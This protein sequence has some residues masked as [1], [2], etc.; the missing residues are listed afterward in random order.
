MKRTQQEILNRIEYVKSRDVLGFEGSDLIEFLDFENAKEYLK[1]EYVKKVEAGSEKWEQPNPV[2]LIKEYLPF[3]WDKANNCRGLSAER[4]LCRFA[5]W[6]W[7]D[8][9]E[10]E[11]IKPLVED[12]SYYGKPELVKISEKYG[13]NWKELDNGKWVKSED[14]TPKTSKDVI[15][16]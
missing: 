11:E 6:L 16:K 5:A 2:S 4:S 8:G 12:Y 13:V 7:M 9:V 15:G 3:A 14:D 1:E 10:E